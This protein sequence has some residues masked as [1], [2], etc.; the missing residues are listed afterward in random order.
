MI[1]T[2][3]VQQFKYTASALVYVV[4]LKLPV[5]TCLY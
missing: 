3:Q 4:N 1:T 5:T 2:Q